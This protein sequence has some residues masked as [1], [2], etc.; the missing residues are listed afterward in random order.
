MVTLGKEGIEQSL[1]FWLFNSL[2]CKKEMMV[3]ASRAVLFFVNRD[4]LN[5]R[6]R[7]GVDVFI[8]INLKNALLGVTNSGL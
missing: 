1:Q 4:K 2:A 5:I 7:Q 3:N 8:L 6:F